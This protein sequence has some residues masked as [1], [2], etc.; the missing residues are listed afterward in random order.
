MQSNYSK[1]WTPNWVGRGT[2]MLN[3][4]E[5]IRISTTKVQRINVSKE[6]RHMLR[7]L[8]RKSPA[9]YFYKSLALQLAKM[10]GLTTK[11]LQSIHSYQ[12]SQLTM[13]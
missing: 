9:N 6:E 13:N 11:Q 2:A 12:K 1:G 7:D 3:S 4:I 10:G 5:T 8:L